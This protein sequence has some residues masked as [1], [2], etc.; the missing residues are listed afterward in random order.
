MHKGIT[1]F[2]FYQIFLKKVFMP[3]R[4]QKNEINFVPS[5]SNLVNNDET[6]YRQTN[7]IKTKAKRIVLMN[8][9]VSRY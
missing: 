7:R 4:S 8:L 3:N 1:F 6:G 5:N 9:L 2:S